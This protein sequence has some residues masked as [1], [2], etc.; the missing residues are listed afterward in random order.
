M[1]MHTLYVK[2]DYKAKMLI[3]SLKNFQQRLDYLSGNLY[4]C[5]EGNSQLLSLLHLG[6][7]AFSVFLVD[8]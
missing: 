1:L 5:L 3:T 7:T 4:P 8:K 2:L 6:I